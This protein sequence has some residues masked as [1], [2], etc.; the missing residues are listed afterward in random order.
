VSG[1][2]GVR[3]DGCA[4][5]GHD[6]NVEQF[7]NPAGVQLTRAIARSAIEHGLYVVA[8]LDADPVGASYFPTAEGWSTPVVDY[9]YSAVLVRAL[10]TESAHA[11][12]LHLR[13]TSALPCAV[14]RPP[15]TH[16]GILLQSDL[17]SDDE[18]EDLARI[19]D[20]WNLPVR[21]ANGERYEINSSLPFIC[22][23]G[24][25]DDMAWRRALL[26]VALTG[27]IPG[28]PYF[29]APFLL[30]DV[31]E[32]RGTTDSDP[33]GLNRGRLSVEHIAKFRNSARFTQ[34]RALLH[35]LQ[36]DR[37]SAA[38]SVDSPIT[39]DVLAD[40]VLTITAEQGTSV[41]ACNFST[42]KPAAVDFGR[43]LHLLWGSG[44]TPSSLAPVGFGVWRVD[45]DTGSAV[46][47][48]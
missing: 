7:H 8:Q 3:L 26:V 47:S 1:I 28:I 38:R 22:S 44:A 32:R 5:Y 6:T 10:L 11:M 20:Q 16:D 42:V 27:I 48:S 9:A 39:V 2:Y 25:D 17:L 41:F 19:S 15:R 36:V 24:V 33:R 12:A 45:G 30:F 21:V 29:Y 23:L 18:R 13:R 35:A 31:P 4:Y 14:L 37:A 34:M 40:S 46:R 43:D